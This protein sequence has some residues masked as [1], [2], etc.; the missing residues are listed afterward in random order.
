MCL[1][2]GTER[3]ATSYTLKPCYKAGSINIHKHY[4]YY[5]INV[6]DIKRRVPSTTDLLAVDPLQVEV[7]EAVDE[8]GAPQSQTDDRVA[9]LL[10]GQLVQTPHLSQGCQLGQMADVGLQED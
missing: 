10:D 1:H 9:L 3:V 6:S 5:C 2:S 4:N 8:E 7:V